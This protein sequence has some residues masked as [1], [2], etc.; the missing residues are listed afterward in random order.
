MGRAERDAKIYTRRIDGFSL[1][2]IAREFE[3]AVETV[4]EIAKRMERKAK[5]RERAVGLG[6][7]VDGNG[8]PGR[9]A[10]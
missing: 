1:R 2:A 5:C 3:L 7:V 6:R 8:T 9:D 4:R 10:P